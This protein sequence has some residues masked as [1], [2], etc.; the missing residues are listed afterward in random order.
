MY[1]KDTLK[2]E[3]NQH[4][5]RSAYPLLN[6]VLQ[7]PRIS[8]SIPNTSIPNGTETSVLLKDFCTAFEAQKHTH[9]R[10][11]LYFIRRSQHHSRPCCQ[12]SCQG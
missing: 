9:N 7:S 8:L 11:L 2:K 12:Q 1:Q 10:Y 6:K 5:P 4:L 3:I